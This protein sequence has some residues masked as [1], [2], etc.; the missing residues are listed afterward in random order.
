MS[1]RS[2]NATQQLI[3]E[4]LPKIF[5]GTSTERWDA[6]AELLAKAKELTKAHLVDDESIREISIVNA[7][8][9]HLDHDYADRVFDVVQ[10]P[11]GGSL[12]AMHAPS[13]RVWQGTGS[14]I[15]VAGSKVVHYV[16]KPGLA[17]ELYG[18]A[19]PYLI[20][21]LGCLAIAH[22]IKGYYSLNNQGSYQYVTNRLH[23]QGRSGLSHI[24]PALTSRDGVSSWDPISPD[25]P[26]IILAS[27][28]GTLVQPWVDAT[29]DRI[30][31][32]AARAV[33]DEA[34][35][36]F[37]GH[38]ENRRAG[39]YDKMFSEM[40]GTA[41]YGGQLNHIGLTTYIPEFFDGVDIN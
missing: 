26:D 21:K 39:L 5:E 18:P 28:S 20:D 31:E 7:E 10:K 24:G 29:F 13:Q 3:L 41:L 32:F 38:I 11:A 4:D 37:D 33:V 8:K 35:G 2:T 12:G 23:R 9:H 34:A 36:L 19:F 27:A 6:Q 1:E 16:N 25:A 30:P 40:I 14:S 22:D 17:A 15:A